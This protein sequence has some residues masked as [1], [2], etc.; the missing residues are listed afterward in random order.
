[1]KKLLLSTLLLAGFGVMTADVVQQSS[2]KTDFMGAYK[3]GET[4]PE[5][6]SSMG[7]DAKV[8]ETMAASFPNYSPTSAY[9]LMGWSSGTAAGAFS[10]SD[11]VDAAGNAVASDQW[12][13]SPEF[14]IKENNELV[15][16]TVLAYGNVSKNAFTVYISEDGASQ[17]DFKKTSLLSASLIGQQNAVNTAMRRIAIEGYAGKK[18]RLAFV[19]NNNKTGMTGFT[20]IGVAPYYMSVE[21]EQ[22]LNEY[23]VMDKSAKLPVRLRVSTPT[24]TKGITAVLETSNG[25]KSTFTNTT[26][27]SKS[28][29]S[30]VNFY[31]PDELNISESCDYTLTITPNFE[32][33]TPTVVYG[34]LVVADAI[35]D[36]NA[37]VEEATGSWCGWCPRGVAYMNYYKDKYN[38]L[39][40]GKVIPIMLHNGDMMDIDLPYIQSMSEQYMALTGGGFGFPTCLVNRVMA[41]D[42]GEVDIESVMN[43]KSVG[44]L[45]I[46]ST[47][48]NPAESENIVVNC[49]GL[50]S[51]DSRDINVAA[52]V[53]ENDV[54]GNNNDW[55]QTDY[56]G[57]YGIAVVEQAY[58]SEVAPY[59]QQF[60]DRPDLFVPYNEM[61]YPEVARAIFPSYAGAPVQGEWEKETEKKFSLWISMPDNMLVKENASV[62]VLMIRNSN[63]EII[64]SDIMDY[65]AWT[66]DPSSVENLDSEVSVNA[67]AVAEGLA[68]NLSA[69]AD[70]EVVSIQ[71]ARL[72]AGHVNAGQTILP[73]AKGQVVIV[74]AVT[75]AGISTRKVIL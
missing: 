53:I 68:L 72:F 15:Y 36:A 3:L 41:G 6:W 17:E 55:N 39:G 56:Y 43:S 64:G 52:V 61:V 11:F 49:S 63:G 60:V 5:G 19:N 12:L 1:M 67:M 69:D 37:L 7:V 70:V 9:R 46:V 34:R 40:K 75:P 18:V 32:G 65:S 48:Y 45:G 38:S 58:G 10:C 31:M 50:L 25:F 24:A 4:L 30:S 62:V 47:Y 42:P 51:Y 21:N 29:V 22:E 71:G 8:G 27:L 66:S 54:K 14:E 57:Q 13:I 26:S 28:V 20:E 16:F 33:A 74:R 2:L 23:L 44:K 35:Y 59:F 73:M